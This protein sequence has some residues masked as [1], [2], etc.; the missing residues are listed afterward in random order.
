MI[1]N[2]DYFN[3][4]LEKIK[5]INYL[6]E[7]INDDSITLSNIEFACLFIID[8]DNYNKSIVKGIDNAFIESMLKLESIELDSDNIK[9]LLDLV[10]TYRISSELNKKIVYKVLDFYNKYSDNKLNI[11]NI[12]TVLDSIN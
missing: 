10:I 11:N 6:N 12:N 3:L 5:S 9:K 1:I 4:C 2:D 7:H 8:K